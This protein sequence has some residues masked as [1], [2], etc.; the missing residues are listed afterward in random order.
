MSIRAVLGS[1]SSTV[2]SGA[3]L[4]P[5]AR[6][7]EALH[8]A[9]VVRAKDDV[10]LAAGLGEAGLDLVHRAA[11]V[12]PDQRLERDLLQRRRALELRERRPGRHDEHVGVAQQL[13]GVVRLALRRATS[14]R[15]G[16]ARPARSSRGARSRPPTRGGRPRPPGAPPRTGGGAW[17]GCACRRSGTSPRAAGPH[18]LP[19]ARACRPSRR[20]AEPRSLLRAG[21]GCAPPR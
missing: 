18:R 1:S 19:R 14:R 12:E 21:R 16:R 7:D 15:S 3:T 6:A 20:A 13:D 9:V 10:R 17:G 8:G 4:T 5:D 2:R 11:A